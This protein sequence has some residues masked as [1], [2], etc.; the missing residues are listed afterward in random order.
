MLP[1]RQIAPPNS[2]IS[3]WPLRQLPSVDHPTG[4]LEFIVDLHDEQLGSVDNQD[5]H[6][7]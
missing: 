2:E 7:E 1:D 5:S 3:A 6:P 4:N